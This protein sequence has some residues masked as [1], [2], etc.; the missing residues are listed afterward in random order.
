M[1][2][3]RDLPLLRIAVVGHTNTGKTSL[4]R[5]LTRNVAF[6][7]V[8]DRPA[9]TR[10]VEGATLNI[11][12]QSAVEL[13]D[14]PGLED[15]INLLDHLDSLGTDRH[16]DHVSVLEQFLKADAEHGPFAQEAKAL[17]Q[18]LECDVALYVIDARD[19]VLAKHRDE[20]AILSR[21]ARPVVPVLNFVVSDQARTA[22][23]R[24]HLSR[25]NMHAVAEFDTVVLDEDG[26][27]R[28]FEKIRTLLDSHATTIDAYLADRQ[29]QTESLIDA[30][31]QVIADAVIDIGAHQIVVSAEDLQ[32]KP[33]L[34]EAF[35]DAIRA[36]ERQCVENLLRLHRFRTGDYEATAQLTINEQLGTDLFSAEA[37]RQY[38]LRAGGA[39]AAG[40]M[41]GLTIDALVGGLSLGTGTAVGAAVGALLEGGWSHGRR[42][43]D[44]LRGRMALHC[45]DATIR[46]FA[47]RQL[48]L[49][50]T[51]LHRGHASPEPV[52]VDHHHDTTTGVSW[53]QRRLPRPLQ[54]ARLHPQWSRLAAARES[55][56]TGH[57]DDPARQAAIHQLGESLRDLMRHVSES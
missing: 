28:L 49:L 3:A 33:A 9:V 44:R 4:L 51:L 26:E 25:L 27:Q 16:A 56:L 48:S 18:V 43:V 45:D 55:G 20:L 34:T 15:S 35:R 21:T 5:T 41:A 46:V 30:S 31:L 37:L 47:L 7:E 52:R 2:D 54:Q 13:Y 8:S 39:A 40:A 53:D 36:R 32:S 57:V 14:T 50:R 10:H 11:N 42:L 17:G 6:G 38:G 24:E 1:I 12:G 19:R 22:E 29:S 23:W